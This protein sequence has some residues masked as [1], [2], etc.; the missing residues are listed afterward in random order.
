M[1]K[2]NNTAQY[3]NQ[4]RRSIEKSTTSHREAKFYN[5]TS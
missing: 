3:S 5:N 2:F 1:T 4:S